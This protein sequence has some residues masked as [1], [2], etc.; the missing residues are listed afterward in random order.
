[1]C[2]LGVNIGALTVKV[3][4]VRGDT[5]EA[6]TVAHQGR[7][8]GRF[9]RSCSRRPGSLTWIIPVCQGIWGTSPRSPPFSEGCASCPAILMRW[10]RWAESPS[11]FTS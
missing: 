5:R 11:W 9:F 6:G 2:H 4:A 7:L 3:V 10:S 1:M 8:P